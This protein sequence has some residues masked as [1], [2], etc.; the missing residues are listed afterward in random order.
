[1][2]PQFSISSPDWNQN[3]VSKSGFN[4]SFMMV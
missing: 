4:L 3:Y 2:G 1:V